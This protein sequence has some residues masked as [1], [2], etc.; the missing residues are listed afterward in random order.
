MAYDLY[1]FD[2]DYTLGDSTDGIIGSSNYATEK[3]GYGIYSDDAIRR[4]IGL[5]LEQTFYTLT[6]ESPSDLN[7]A[8]ASEFRRLF[9]ERADHIMTPSTEFLPGA[10][11]TLEALKEKGHFTAI[12]T[13]KI[14]RRIKDIFNKYAVSHLID[15]IVGFDDVKIGKP[16]PQGVYSVLERTGVSPE[17]TLY[18]GDSVVD[19]KTAMNAGISFAGVTT[20]STTENELSV[21]PYI[22]ITKDIR[23]ILE[24]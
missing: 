22:L 20:G 5:T 2:F 8:K 19:A 24:L 12:V 11:E 21:F 4:T 7:S 1:I 10:V 18:I 6:G 17:K 16:D 13:T 14:N 9:I 15:Y 23:E 3:M